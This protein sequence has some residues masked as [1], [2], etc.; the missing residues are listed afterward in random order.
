[1]SGRK[2]IFATCPACKAYIEVPKFHKDEAARI[3]SKHEEAYHK[4]KIVPGQILKGLE[5]KT[6]PKRLLSLR[7]MG[8]RL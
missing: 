2:T 8:G 1:M 6:K 7:A 4:G 3:L 5:L